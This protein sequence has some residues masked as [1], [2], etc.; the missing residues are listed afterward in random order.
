LGV[1]F[2]RPGTKKG[3]KAIKRFNTEEKKTENEASQS[4]KNE[5]NFSENQRELNENG[6]S[7]A[8]SLLGKLTLKFGNLCRKI[9]GKIQRIEVKTI[10]YIKRN[11]AKALLGFFRKD[12]AISVVFIA[13]TLVTAGNLNFKKEQSGFLFAS[14][15]EEVSVEELAQKRLSEA[16]VKKGNLMT[17]PL[18]M[19]TTIEKEE[20]IND[21]VM[22]DG[23]LSQNQMQYQV[24][25]ATEPPNAKELLSQGADVS[26]YEVKQG[27]T[28]STIAQ[29]FGVT[30][31]TILWANDLDDPDMI[32]PGDK[33]FVLPITGVKHVVKADETLKKIADKYKADMERI[34]AFNELPADGRIKEGEEIIIPGGQIEQPVTTPGALLQERSYYSSDVVRD[35]SRGP[36]I[37]D[38]NPKG[39]HIFP[40]GYC[41]WYVASKKYVPWGG[42]AGTWLYNARA[43]GVKTGKTP[44]KGAIIVTNESWYGHVGI[45]TKVSGDKVTISEM[46]YKGFGVVSSRTI[47]SKSR[48][49]KGYIY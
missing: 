31:N 24:L 43:Y 26:V 4:H 14:G 28:V 41:T 29:D 32:Q 35:D 46:N 34:I 47:S 16:S 12:S 8:R 11:R 15:E 17:A 9:P 48:V 7:R 10:E 3:L 38:R 39:G 18:T 30:T 20:S 25:T 19:N 33:I 13:T 1:F 23:N 21:I 5:V 40:Y 2:Y 22:K 49:I 27:D 6:S 36:S 42:N 37:I 45:V 44:K